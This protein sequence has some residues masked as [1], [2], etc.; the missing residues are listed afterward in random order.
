MCEYNFP[1]TIRKILSARKP[2]LIQ[3][4][5][6]YCKHAGVL[7]PLFKDDGVHKV[8]FTKRSYAVEYHKGQISFPGGS[9]DR[10]DTS[11]EETALRETQE[12]IGLRREDIKIL[13]RIDDTMTIES[14][15]L[16]HPFVGL[17][18][19]PYNFTISEAEVEKLITVPL[20]IF[21]SGK[22][23]DNSHLFE[24]KGNVFSTLTYEYDNEIIRGATARMMQNFMDILCGQQ[25]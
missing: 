7:I 6:S 19:Y 22:S 15:F 1:D 24:S 17:L 2:K 25:S 12:E 21:H 18:P 5:R 4:S 8:L 3:D 13:G 11:L 23:P 14:K 10:E 9:V 20:E 16:V